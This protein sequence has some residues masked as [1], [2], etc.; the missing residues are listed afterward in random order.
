M[1]YISLA[2]FNRILFQVLA[3][4]LE[5]CPRYKKLFWDYLNSTEGKQ[6]YANYTDV[7]RYLEHHTGS[8]MNSKAFA[9]LYFTLT[10]EVCVLLASLFFT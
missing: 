9:D 1:F 6:L 2:D 3:D 4:P 10:T 5:N 7:I 8:P